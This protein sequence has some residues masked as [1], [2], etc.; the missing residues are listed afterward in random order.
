[1]EL[2]MLSGSAETLGKKISDS[3]KTMLKDDMDRSQLEGDEHEK[4]F[5]I[6]TCVGAFMIFWYVREH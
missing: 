5:T 3:A 6:D 4:K 1:M 2:T